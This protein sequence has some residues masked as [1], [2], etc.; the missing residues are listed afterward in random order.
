[1][2]ESLTGRAGQGSVSVS[3]SATLEA[4]PQLDLALVARN[5]RPVASDLLTAVLDADLALHGRVGDGLAASGR[6]GLQHVEIRIPERMPARLPTLPIRIAGAPPAPAEV[7]APPIAL[8]IRI[9]APG[10]VFV[11]GR[12]LEAELAGAV[13]IGGTLDD[14]RPDGA[15]TLRRGSFNLLGTPLTLTEGRVTLD[16]SGALDP[17]IDFAAT[18]RTSAANATVRVTGHAS[19]PEI[20]LTSEPELPQDEILA[21][22][23]LGRSLNRVSALQAAQIAAGIAELSGQGIGFDPLGRIRGGL[24]L[25][26]LAIGSTE[27]GATTLEAGRTIA[28]GVYLGVRQ[29]TGDAGTRATVQ[30]DIGRGLKL[31][32]EVGTSTGAPSA[33]GAGASNGSSVGVVW[34]RE[35]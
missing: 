18:S 12:G 33:T 29:G 32:G 6:I 16:G 30:I 5:A 25:D 23:L 14:P 10:R 19:A 20:R 28:P 9:T 11:R 22:L 31:Q 3:G 34:S 8:D 13:A 27:S 15:L 26:R 21:Q 4:A 1:V 24:G 2:I 7:P 35:W 17:A